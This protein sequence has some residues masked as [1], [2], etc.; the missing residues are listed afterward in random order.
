MDLRR[1]VRFSIV[2]FV[3]FL[4]LINLWPLLLRR[5]VPLLSPLRSLG[6]V[7]YAILHFPSIYEDYLR[8]KK[9]EFELGFYKSYINSLKEENQRLR[10]LLG[11]PKRKG[12]R[13]VVAD[14]LA[15]PIGRQDFF[16][17]NVGSDEGVRP[18]CGVMLPGGVVCGRV[19]EVW[20]GISKAVYPWHL[21]FSAVVIDEVSREEGVVE[22][23]EVVKMRFLTPRAEVSKGDPVRTSALSLFFPRGLLLGEI[24]D[25]HCS[26]GRIDCYAEVNPCVRGM[27]F[28]QVVVLVPEQGLPASEIGLGR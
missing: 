21:Q 26:P 16:Y 1:V 11:M 24:N 18:G 8:L 10:T 5:F 4:L 9:E 14:V 27:V 20:E 23:G 6:E 25:F 17:L 13:Q 7:G 19:V 3:S 22:G 28:Y 2:I 15:Q 12:F